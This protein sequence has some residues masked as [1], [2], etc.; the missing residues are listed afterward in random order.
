M[1]YD[2]MIYALKV[3]RNH[4]FSGQVRMLSPLSPVS[5]P[6]FYLCRSLYLSKISPSH[7]GSIVLSH[8]LFFSSIDLPMP[9]VFHLPYLLSISSISD[10]ISLFQIHLLSFY[11]P[12]ILSLDI[13]SR[14]HFIVLFLACIRSLTLSVV[15]SS[16]CSS[17][18]PLTLSRSASIIYFPLLI[19]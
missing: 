12:H 6:S 4:E 7:S 19:Y 8:N 17:D 2:V 3:V 18:S 10:F 11:L 13:F 15:H 14:T 1:N 16:S 9:S 5:F